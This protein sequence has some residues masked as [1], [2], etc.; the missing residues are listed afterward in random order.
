MD[1]SAPG[2][3]SA[4]DLAAAIRRKDVSPVEVVD[5]ALGRIEQFNP[6]LNAFSEVLVDNA[7]DAARQAE[8]AVNDGADLGPL[9]GVPIGIKNQMN[10]T[11]ARV[12]FGTH[13]LADYV[14]T[15]DA[16]VVAGVR[17]AGAIVVGMTTMPEFGWQG[18]S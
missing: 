11:G 15:E 9:H 6:T 5:A 17:R 10:V 12:T 1:L 13:L 7:R 2:F 4:L 14:A 18:I 8:A 16:P 3:S